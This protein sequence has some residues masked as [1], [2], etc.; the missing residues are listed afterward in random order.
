MYF[1][2]YDSIFYLLTHKASF[3]LSTNFENHKANQVKTHILT[4]TLC[5]NMDSLYANF[6]IHLT[7][8][9]HQSTIQ[10]N[11]NNLLIFLRLSI[12][13]LDASAYIDLSLLIFSVCVHEVW[14][15][16]LGDLCTQQC[17]EPLLFTIWQR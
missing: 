8:I 9:I 3:Y 10:F 5:I 1:Q 6:A 7:S 13:V 11:N 14:K 17:H 16:T 2:N 12:T 15:G 4:Y